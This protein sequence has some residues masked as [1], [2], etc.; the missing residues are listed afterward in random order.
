MMAID[1][2]D[3]VYRHIKYIRMSF[4]VPTRVFKS[5]AQRYM[6]DVDGSINIKTGQ[7]IDTYLHI[8]NNLLTEYKH[9]FDI[10]SNACH[11]QLQIPASSMTELEKRVTR[12]ILLQYFF[13]HT[14]VAA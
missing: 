3:M 5:N 6:V 14:P 7:A 11:K 10:F 2:Q 4:L 12:A 13:V 1:H 8:Y 9:R